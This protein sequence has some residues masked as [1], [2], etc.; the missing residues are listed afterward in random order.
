MNRCSSWPGPHILS[1]TREAGV[2][3]DFPGDAYF[4][5]ATRGTCRPNN[6]PQ[7]ETKA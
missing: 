3:W 5:P 1:C 7:L 4:V 6:G 2:A